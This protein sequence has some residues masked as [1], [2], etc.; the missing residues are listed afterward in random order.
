MGMSGQRRFINTEQEGQQCRQLPDRIIF[1]LWVLE[2][3]FHT[4]LANNIAIGSLLNFDLWQSHSTLEYNTK[5]DVYP[6]EQLILQLSIATSTKQGNKQHKISVETKDTQPCYIASYCL[7]L[8]MSGAINYFN[9]LCSV[10]FKF[11]E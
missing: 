9:T 6:R 10:H 11:S 1:S 8:M 4:Y 7:L 2:L 5:N 3:N